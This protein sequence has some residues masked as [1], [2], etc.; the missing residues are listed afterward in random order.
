MRLSPNKALQGTSPKLRSSF[1]AA[2][3]LGRYM[4]YELDK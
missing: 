1:G 2:P 4:V 3:E